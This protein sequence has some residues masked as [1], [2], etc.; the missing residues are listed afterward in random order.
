MKK[1]LSVFSV[2]LLFVLCSVSLFGCGGSDI[3]MLF[4]DGNVENDAIGIQFH[5][6]DKLTDGYKLKGFF[7]AQSEAKLDRK[8]VFS[9]SQENG[10]KAGS[11]TFSEQ[12]LF[13]LDCNQLAD[14]KKV[15]FE[16][17]FSKVADLFPETEETAKIYFNFHDENDLAYN[18]FTWSSLGFDYTCKNGQVSFEF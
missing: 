1:F 11:G 15:N 13:E 7:Y 17:E 8:V 10:I 12:V 3:N 5:L 18:I 4:G 2:V 14:G 9:I 16:I 6:D